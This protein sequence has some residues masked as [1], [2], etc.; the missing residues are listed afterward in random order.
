[1]FSAADG[2]PAKEEYCR[3]LN[4]KLMENTFDYIEKYFNGS[5]TNEEKAHFEKKRFEDKE[6]DRE[7]SIYEK[8]NAII[9]ERARNRM[10]AQ[11]DSIGR[12]QRP[13]ELTDTLSGNRFIRK[14]WLSMAASILFI[15]AIAFFALNSILKQ[16]TTDTL[17][18]LYESG[19]EKPGIDLV[20]TRSS[21]KDSNEILWNSGLEFYNKS[22]YRPALTRFNEL[23]KS[24]SFVLKSAAYFYAGICYM[25]LNVSDSASLYLIN[26]S[27]SSALSDESRWYLALNY[28][29]EGNIPDAALILEQIKENENHPRQKEASRLLKKMR[30]L[31]SKGRSE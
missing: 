28:I 13:I 7:V 16:G 18:D 29:N 27:Q 17:A 9:R 31:D 20:I 12:N 22:E 10:K 6:F 14:Y 4:E 2:N 30:K 24:P 11:L 3:I 19:F 1:L 5:L 23:L 25:Q 26:V 15:S 8:A 21:E